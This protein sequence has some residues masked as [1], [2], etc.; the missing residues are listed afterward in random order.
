MIAD[1]IFLSNVGDH[2]MA[3]RINGEQVPLRTELKN[4]GSRTLQLGGLT[5][6]AGITFTFTNGASLGPGQLLVL[7]RN[8]AAFALPAAG[9]L[10]NHTINSIEGPGFWTVDLA[11]SRLVSLASTK[12]L[13]LRVEIFN[14]FNNFN[15]GLPVTNFNAGTFGK[16]T[17]AGGDP[18]IMQFGLKYGF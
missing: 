15:W 13:E 7:A 14:L 4:T 6:T 11:I 16:I 3:A 2:A 12:Q 1:D 9:T 5:F 8:P 10:G 18:R 17:T